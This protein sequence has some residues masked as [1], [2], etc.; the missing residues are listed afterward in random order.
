VL[1]HILFVQVT[2]FHWHCFI[3]SEQLRYNNNN[4]YYYY[5]SLSRSDGKRS[6]WW[7]DFDSLA[8][9][10]ALCWDVTVVCPVANSGCN[11]ICRCYGRNG[12]HPQEYGALES[13]HCFQH[14]A[15]ESLGPMNCDARQFLSDLRRRISCSSWDDWETF[16]LFQ[17]ISVSLF[18]FNSVLLH[19]GF[20]LLWRLNFLPVQSTARTKTKRIT[21]TR[22]CTWYLRPVLT[23]VLAC[24]VL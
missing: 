23:R 2:A 10:Q 16:Y 7:S 18:R 15:L 9:M 1:R 8:G 20:V 6:E 11:W 4:N 17:R 3:N 13:Q 14:I 12:R 24:E 19:D 21:T 5:N 22:S